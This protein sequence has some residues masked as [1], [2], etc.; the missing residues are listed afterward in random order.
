MEKFTIKKFGECDISDKFFDTLKADYPGFI[1][2]YNGHL[3]RDVYINQDT[4]GIRA[5]LILKDGEQ[6][7]IILKDR[8]L[9]RK[10]RIKICTLKLDENIRE[11]RLGEGTIGIAL[12]HWQKRP[13]DE[14]YIT[15]FPKHA[16]LINLLQRFGF[17][18]VGILDNGECIF[19]KSKVNLDKSS[20]YTM[21][22]YIS[23]TS[24]KYGIL[25]VD[26]YYHDTLFPYSQVKNKEFFDNNM[27]VSNGVSKIFIATPYTPTTY[28]ENEPVL[29]YRKFRGKNPGYNSVITSFCTITKIHKIRENGNYLKSKEEYL[30]IIKNKSVY[31]SETLEKIYNQ[32]NNIVIIEMVYNGYFGKGNNINW[33]YLSNNGYWP[34][35]PYQIELTKNQFTEI[36]KMGTNNEKNIII[37]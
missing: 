14:I 7:E 17:N 4:N 1:D 15:V 10:S 13:E 23:S 20:P 24:E 2:W 32:K 26:D 22:P 21:F 29:V 30:K 25:V 11:R 6:D 36:L 28:V 31:D 9:P 12:W 19:I 37:D 18:K 34:K 33:V 16:L 5:L 35:H 27:A 3:D 8:T